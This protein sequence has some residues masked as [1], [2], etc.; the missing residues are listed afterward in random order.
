MVKTILVVDDD[1][2]QRRL[3]RAVCE[4]AG[5]PVL[6]A[7]DGESAMSLLQSQQGADVALIMLD[8]RMPGLGGMGG[9]GGLGGQS[10]QDVLPGLP[11]GYLPPGTPSGARKADVR[12]SKNKS[13]NRKK[14]KKARAA[15]KKQRRK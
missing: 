1:P 3:M 10:V 2:T 9:F 15:R 5:Y 7:A 13:A 6:Q 12:A 4:K 11:K 8:L 14:N